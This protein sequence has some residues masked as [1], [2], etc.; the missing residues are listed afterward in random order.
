MLVQLIRYSI[1]AFLFI[2]CA[3]IFPVF[4]EIQ[5]PV[6]PT[7]EKDEK[8]PTQEKDEKPPSQDS[9]D[10]LFDFQDA[11]GSDLIQEP[12]R[13]EGDAVV[14]VESLD[15]EIREQSLENT[16]S[17]GVE[18]DVDLATGRAEDGQL[19]GPLD[20][21]EYGELSKK[22]LAQILK[23]A[24]TNK[25][26]KPNSLVEN[27]VNDGLDS[28]EILDQIQ[29]DC[30]IDGSCNLP[31]NQVDKIILPDQELVDKVV[32]EALRHRD[33]TF[34]GEI[35]R[36]LCGAF[37]LFCPIERQSLEPNQSSLLSDLS[38]RLFYSNPEGSTKFITLDY[39]KEGDFLVLKRTIGSKS[40]NFSRG[41][42]KLQ[43]ASYKVGSKDDLSIS[44]SEDGVT[45]I[46]LTRKIKRWFSEDEIQVV[47]IVVKR[48]LENII[49]ESV[50]EDSEDDP[51]DAHLSWQESVL[52]PL[53]PFRNN[54]EY[55]SPLG[56]TTK[57]DN[58]ECLY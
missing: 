2:S 27:I 43:C 45:S 5:K 42:L 49:I 18:V 36:T 4:Q 1:V 12:Q 37:N 58:I 17:E 28:G 3:R 16:S 46:R 15:I 33:E 6:I 11:D 7:Q 55:I 32:K 39:N 14:A 56:H 41:T 26:N 52:T 25:N 8:L 38:G 19:G 21:Q 9:T 40:S 51:V 48:E 20:L 31:S 57:I 23:D 13:R 10:T 24:L 44:S 22:D 34:M 50:H 53:N 54:Y 35:S 47:N 30:A 29:I